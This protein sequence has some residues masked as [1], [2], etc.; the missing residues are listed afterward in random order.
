MKHSSGIE[1]RRMRTQEELADYLKTHETF[2]GFNREVL[3]PYMSWETAKD[4]FKEE[5]RQSVKE[6]FEKFGY[7][8]EQDPE[9]IL[10]EMKDYYGF[11]VGKA[12]DHRGISANRSI[13]KMEAWVW[14][15]NDGNLDKIHWSWYENYGAPILKEIGDIYGFKYLADVDS[16]DEWGEYVQRDNE[17][18]L[19]MANGKPCR[20]DCEEGCGR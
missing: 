15:L 6:H 1:K 12:L 11:A 20:D 4:F 2:L 5:G 9:D 19:R 16:D 10:A 7:P 3:L 8:K 14:L 18:F 13:E 17:R